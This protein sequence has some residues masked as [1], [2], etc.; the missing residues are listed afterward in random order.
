MADRPLLTP[1]FFERSVFEVAPDLIG[2]NIFTTIDGVRVGGMIIETEAYHQADPFAH[3]F[4]NDEIS[5]SGHSSP[6]LESPGSLYLYWA[7]QLP[8]LNLV[9]EPKGVG[10][11]VLIRALL[12]ICNI[13]A[14]LVRR[15]AW[16]N[17][18]DKPIPKY[19]ADAVKRDR[20]LCNGPA[21]LC[22]ALG[23]RD[24]SNVG[25]SIFH[26]PF[27]IWQPVERPAVVAGIRIGLDKQLKRW[28]RSGANGALRSKLPSINEFGAKKWRWGAADFR[29]YC[30]HS[31]FEQR[32]PQRSDRAIP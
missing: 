13:G 1:K 27:E 12:P 24:K 30:R 32:W 23:I 9:C 22:E 16:Y 3:C 31:S 20:N 2:C 5:M 18:R 19:L 4:S 25:P 21:V 10:S 17:E 11:A 15:T 29:S 14:M 26:T 8:C 28:E 6:M 7:S